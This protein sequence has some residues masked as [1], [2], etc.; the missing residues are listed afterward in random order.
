MIVPE[1]ANAPFCALEQADCETKGPTPLCLLRKPISTFVMRH[2]S[3]L[4]GNM[5]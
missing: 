3:D 1:H 2:Q 4:M 5:T